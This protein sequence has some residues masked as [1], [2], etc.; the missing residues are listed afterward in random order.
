MWSYSGSHSLSFHSRVVQDGYVEIEKCAS[1][2]TGSDVYHLRRLHSFHPSNVE[3]KRLIAL[4]SGI[5]L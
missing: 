2:A 5:Y 1:G 3:C 4:V